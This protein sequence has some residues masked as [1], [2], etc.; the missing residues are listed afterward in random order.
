[1]SKYKMAKGKQAAPPKAGLPCVILV[2]GLVIAIGVF[3]FLVMKY[4]S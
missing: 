2:I 4:A 1:M 3:I